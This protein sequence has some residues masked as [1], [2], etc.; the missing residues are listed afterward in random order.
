MAGSGE[1]PRAGE[2]AGKGARFILNGLAATATHYVSLMLL[3]EWLGLRPVG[4]MNLI[5]AALGV[6]VSYLGN[7]HFVFR[8]KRR[9]RD[10]LGS[11]SPTAEDLVRP[12]ICHDFSSPNSAAY[13]VVDYILAQ[14][15]RKIGG[16][17]ISCV[18]QQ[19]SFCNAE[20][21]CENCEGN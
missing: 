1:V 17:T 19:T 8:S 12:S 5:A 21:K 6:A 9:Q 13:S 4:L 7:H 10:T 14:P 15:W 16:T 3:A 18:Q 2:E 11:Y 20:A